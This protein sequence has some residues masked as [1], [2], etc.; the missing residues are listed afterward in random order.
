MSE[1]AR[2]VAATT[3]GGDESHDSRS[4]AQAEHQLKELERELAS[5][6]KQN[7]EQLA[8]RDAEIAKLRRNLETASIAVIDRRGGGEPALPPPLTQKF[9]SFYRNYGRLNNQ[10]ITVGTAFEAAK[11]LNWTVYLRSEE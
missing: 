5:A 7:T 2:R 4:I 8:A 1:H 11:Y 9:V 6:K 10:L 3:I